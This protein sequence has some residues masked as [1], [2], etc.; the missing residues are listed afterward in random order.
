M[1]I[2]EQ[3]IQRY[4]Q[5]DLPGRQLAALDRH[6]STCLLCTQALAADTT[7]EWERRGLLGRLVRV[8]R[9]D[10]TDAGVEAPETRAA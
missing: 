7:T 8:E 6:V 2:D 1:H 5:R 4:A 9:P 3:V 10:T